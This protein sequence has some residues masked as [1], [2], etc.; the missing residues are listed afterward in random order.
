MTLVLKIDSCLTTREMVSGYSGPKPKKDLALP[1]EIYSE[2]VTEVA[3]VME[4]G[5]L[6]NQ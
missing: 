1:L 3:P 5:P 4:V 6:S 2:S